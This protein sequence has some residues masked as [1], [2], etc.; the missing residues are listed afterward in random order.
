MNPNPATNESDAALDRLLQA[1]LAAPAEQLT[2]SSGFALSVM[3]SIHQQA[4][5]PPPI[6]F[7]WRRVLPGAIAILCALAGYAL[8]VVTGRAGTPV[9]A[10]APWAHLHASSTFTS[11]EVVLFSVLVAA[12]VSA[13]AIAASFRL[14]GRSR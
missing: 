12:S 2:P 5:E 11:G 6:A 7:P 14:A 3:D 10:A 8:F 13:I 1:H 4:T 9:F